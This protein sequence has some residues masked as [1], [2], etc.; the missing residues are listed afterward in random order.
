[1]VAI[2]VSL[3]DYMQHYAE[4][5]CEWVEGVVVKMSPVDERH[6]G[7]N[8][9]LRQLLAAFF[10]LRPI[11]VVRMQPF[12]MRL[13]AF[14]NRRREPDL[15][16]ILHTNPHELKAT[17]MDGPADI[18]IEIVSEESVNRDH[19]EKFKEYEQGGVP[20]YW[21]ADPLHREARFYRLNAEGLYQRQSE[22]ADGYYRT[23]ALPGLL[24]HVPTFWQSEFPG[25]LA[26]AQAVAKMLE[27][28]G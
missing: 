6:D 4:D 28:E 10:E 5:F 2:D 18:V 27:D 14:P 13:P 23:P 20:E 24:I 11:G 16:V 19:G 25:P 22:D 15:M 17:Y 7:L 9:Y 21:I 8:Y 3:E 12:V 1:V 26:T